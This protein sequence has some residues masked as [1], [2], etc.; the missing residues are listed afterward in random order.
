VQIPIASLF[1][2]DRLIYRTV[3][4]SECLCEEKDFCKEVHT[5]PTLTRPVRRPDDKDRQGSFE[6]TWHEQP[7]AAFWRA[8]HAVVLALV[9]PSWSKRGSA[10]GVL[11]TVQFF[12]GFS[13]GKSNRCRKLCQTCVGVLLCGVTSTHHSSENAPSKYP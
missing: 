4:P 5:S 9:C 13:K 2:A 10:F 12:F 3:M 11:V 1:L 8:M 6:C 7:R